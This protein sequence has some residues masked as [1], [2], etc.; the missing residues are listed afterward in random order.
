[1]QSSPYQQC[2]ASLQMA[3]AML[4]IL[5]APCVHGCSHPVRHYP[6]LSACQCKTAYINHSLTQLV[7]LNRLL[8]QC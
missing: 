4:P 5:L 6:P 3:V 8:F 1:M 7:H 2:R